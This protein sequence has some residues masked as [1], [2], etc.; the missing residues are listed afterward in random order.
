MRRTACGLCVILLLF[1]A[2]WIMSCGGSS[3]P[4]EEDGFQYEVNIVNTLNGEDTTRDIDVVQSTCDDG[5]GEQIGK[6]SAIIRVAAR[7]D[8]PDSMQVTGYTFRLVP[9]GGAYYES[10]GADPST[11]V[12]TTVD[13]SPDLP[14]AL[15]TQRRSFNSPV[16]GPGD[17][18]EFDIEIWTQTEKAAYVE[19]LYNNGYDE[20]VYLMLY[21]DTGAPIGTALVGTEAEFAQFEY[22][23]FVTLH[24]RA[25]GDNF[26]LDVSP[27]DNP[28]FANYNNCE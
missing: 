19:Y 26:N 18:V 12:P 9:A 4:L 11:L 7:A 8:A 14:D 10:D 3:G 13:F 25:E 17:S 21:D 27:A 20:D 28:I 23:L 24:C 1:G 2:S 15:R 6:F 16:I 5:T 22:D